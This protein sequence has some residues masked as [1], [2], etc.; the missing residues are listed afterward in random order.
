VF[1]AQ[2]YSTYSYFVRQKYTTYSNIDR[3]GI[4]EPADDYEA[5]SAVRGV[6]YTAHAQVLWDFFA[7]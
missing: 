4:Q 5:S 7:I 1:F 2:N 6:R 3:M